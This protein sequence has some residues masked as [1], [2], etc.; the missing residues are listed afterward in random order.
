MTRAEAFIVKNIIDSSIRTKRPAEL[1]KLISAKLLAGNI[2]KKQKR[3]T[4]SSF[5]KQVS[6]A[7]NNAAMGQQIINSI[8]DAGFYEMVKQY[9]KDNKQHLLYRL[10]ADGSLNYHDFELGRSNGK[11]YIADMFIYV[12]GE[13]L[14]QTI[15]NLSKNVSDEVL[16]S[17]KDL[18]AL[19]RMKQLLMENKHEEAKKVYDR[20][21]TELRDQRAL[22]VMHLLICSGLDEETYLK[23][24]DRFRLMYPNE[25]YMFLMM[26]DASI[27]K[28]EYDDALMY[29]NKTDSVID[30][31]PFL[32]Y[33]RGLLYKL[34]EDN[35]NATKYFEMVTRSMPHFSDGLLALIEQYFI[36]KKY[37]KAKGTIAAYKKNKDYNE[38]MLSLL[39][40]SYPGYKE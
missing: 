33:Y 6:I 13:D 18:A 26:I 16:E 27:M 8:K 23:A 17:E 36:E 7:L 30:K 24:I 14:S 25:P 5:V 15:S 32:D 40:Y 4:G 9:E 38:D 11:V 22:Q 12:S 37:D 31:D 29:V 28:K 3:R 39:R 1:N 2:A 19:K 10:Y 21:P 20:L 35:E 34:K